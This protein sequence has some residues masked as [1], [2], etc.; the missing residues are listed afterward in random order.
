MNGQSGRS[1]STENRHVAGTGKLFGILIIVLGFL[2]LVAPLAMGELAILAAGAFVVVAGILRI[3]WALQTK[4]E[5]HR[6]WRLFSGILV[7]LAG[8]AVLAHPLLASGILT[9]MLATYLFMEG[10]V[11]IITALTMPA[12]SSKG[13]VFLG[14]L[15]STALA[16]L[17]FFQSPLSGVLA[18]GVY[19]GIRLIVS[20]VTL[21]VVETTASALTRQQGSV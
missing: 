13:W 9:L 19:L 21:I 12:Q 6:F 18:I 16:C 14:S 8:G 15:T 3:L 1:E 4:S 17:L 7:I 2:T 10:L 11:E 5:G 20:G